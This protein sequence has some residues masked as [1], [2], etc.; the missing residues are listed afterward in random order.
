MSD[1]CVDEYGIEKPYSQSERVADEL[2]E[3]ADDGALDK[4]QK[5]LRSIPGLLGAHFFDEMPFGVDGCDREKYMPGLLGLTEEAHK[6]HYYELRAEAERKERERMIPPYE[7]ATEYSYDA[8]SGNYVDP[9]GAPA[10][11]DPGYDPG[12]EGCYL[13]PEEIYGDQYAP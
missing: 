1:H 4:L 7:P 5:G 11:H 2:K 13:P 12:A 10:S 3:D 6:K 8:E 9:S